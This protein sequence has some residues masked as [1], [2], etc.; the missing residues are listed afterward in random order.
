MKLSQKTKLSTPKMAE[1][2][3]WYQHVFGMV[4]VEEWDHDDDKGV[5]SLSDKDGNQLSMD[6]SGIRIESGEDLQVQAKG[7]ISVKGTKVD[8]K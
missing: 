5:I 3:A 1:V 7:N 4:V 8:V 2:Q 6:K